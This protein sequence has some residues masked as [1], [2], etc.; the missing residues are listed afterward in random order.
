MA[1]NKQLQ[2]FNDSNFGQM[3]NNGLGLVNRN[4]DVLL[5]I[6]ILLILALLIVP[7]APVILDLFLAVSIALSV[8]ILMVS[9]Y[10]VKPLEFS[11][12]PSILLITTLFRLGLNVAT[13][14][15]ILGEAAA[16][17]IIHAFGN[18]VISGNYVVGLIIFIIL[19][20]INFIVVIKGST[21][22]AEVAARFTLDA[23]PGKQMS[24]DADL[25]AGYI[26]EQTARKRREELTKESDFYGSMDG[27]AKFIKGDAIAAL[28]I[29][30]INLIGGFLIGMIQKG[31]AFDQAVSTYSI[32]TIGDG[33]VSQIP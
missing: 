27:A 29:T 16:G 23:L 14:R 3:A 24:I 8:M 9:I 32:L 33:L 30:A 1:K 10:L 12:F 19:L 22:I 20:V 28:I 13:T 17:D 18:F 21:R 11:A 4:K 26:D 5:A 7:L 6:G 2:A 31:M 25:N 15:L